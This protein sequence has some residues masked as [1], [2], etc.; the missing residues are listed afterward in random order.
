MELQALHC[1][2]MASSTSPIPATSSSAGPSTSSLHSLSSIQQLLQ[3]THNLTS[4]YHHSLSQLTTRLHTL[5]D[6]TTRLLNEQHRLRLGLEWLREKGQLLP[7]SPLPTPAATAAPTAATDLTTTLF[8]LFTQPTASFTSRPF[9]Y[10]TEVCYRR[11]LWYVRRHPKAIVPAALAEANPTV[12]LEQRRWLGGLCRGLVCDVMGDGRGVAEGD[13]SPA[14]AVALIEATLVRMQTVMRKRTERRRAEEDEARLQKDRDDAQQRQVVTQPSQPHSNAAE[15]MEDDESDVTTSTSSTSPLP[16][17]TITTT[18]ST[19]TSLLS[20]TNSDIPIL[21]ASSSFT[22]SVLDHSSLPLKL[23]HEFNLRYG[24]RYLQSTLVSSIQLVLEEQHVDLN[25]DLMGPSPRSAGPPTAGSSAVAGGG[26]GEKL[27]GICGHLMDAIVSSA[28]AMPPGMRRLTRLLFRLGSSATS[29]TA[30]FST[31]TTGLMSSPSSPYRLVSDYLFLNYLIN[32]LM[33]P[34]SY[35]LLPLS[36]P[37]LSP[38]HRRNLQVVAT[39]LIKVMSGSRFVFEGGRLQQLN[40]AVEEWRE[41]VIRF[42]DGL[43]DDDEAGS[44]AVELKEEG[45][46]VGEESGEGEWEEEGVGEDREVVDRVI[47]TLPNDLFCLH[48]VLLG[49][50]RDEVERGRAQRQLEREQ[51]KASSALHSPS[52]SSR[53][54]PLS[55]LV[56]LLVQMDDPP[57]YLSLADNLYILL[58]S[59]F[60]TLAVP[61][62]PPFPSSSRTERLCADMLSYVLSLLPRL[63][64]PSASSTSA[65]VLTVLAAEAQRAES[66][67][68][69]ATAITVAECI[70]LLSSSLPLTNLADFLTSLCAHLQSYHSLLTSSSLP[71]R[72]LLCTGEVERR[73]E[74]LKRQE[75]EVRDGLRGLGVRRVME[76]VRVR[77]KR[78]RKF[79]AQRS[80]KEKDKLV[81]QDKDRP[82]NGNQALDTTQQTRDRR[83]SAP[84]SSPLYVPPPPAY[85]STLLTGGGCSGPWPADIQSDRFLC[86]GCMRLLDKRRV[87]LRSFYNKYVIGEPIGTATGVDVAAA[88]LGG[89]SATLSLAV[90]LPLAPAVSSPAVLSNANSSS[91]S[92][93]LSASAPSAG[94]TIGTEPGLGHTLLNLS[95][96]PPLNLLDQAVMCDL[97]DL[98]C[99][100]VWDEVWVDCERGEKQWW[101]ECEALRQ[102][103]LAD[104]DEAINDEATGSDRLDD[105]EMMR[106]AFEVWYALMALGEREVGGD[107]GVTVAD[108]RRLLQDKQQQPSTAGSATEQPLQRKLQQLSAPWLSSHTVVAFERELYGMLH[109]KSCRDKL[110]C[111][112][113]MRSIVFAS[114]ANGSMIA[115]RRQQR[116]D[117]SESDVEAGSVDD[118]M[119]LLSFLLVWLNPL[120]VLPHLSF[121]RLLHVPAAQHKAMVDVL[122]AVKYVYFMQQ[123]LASAKAG[124]AGAVEF[125]LNAD[126]LRQRVASRGGRPASS[127]DGMSGRDSSVSSGVEVDGVPMAR[128]S[129]QPSGLTSSGGGRPFARSLSSLDEH[130]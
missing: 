81:I 25:I 8:A 91:A 48:W 41:R 99:S 32:A 3:T 19:L 116:G 88:A 121:L 85:L 5:D 94:V 28:A 114:L 89:N 97:N 54:V 53:S 109:S 6:R 110:D 84:T 69:A 86:A 67:G 122:T 62:L 96:G 4:S 83:V 45:E 68:N 82:V 64:P 78:L 34:S 40:E 12:L 37:P 38:L 51:R 113:R 77:V 18:P 124:A 47:A 33:H 46:E 26:A 106:S 43:V 31:S 74:E 36:S 23:L 57:P 72:L 59:G 123:S 107:S 35:S 2:S 111:I 71:S 125:A 100:A 56:A 87:L 21:T 75:A 20:S 15:H 95:L 115:L 120:S 7:S 126:R 108:V 55:P 11:L 130:E 24:Q 80:D 104:V 129:S 39:V 127:V 50:K 70:A 105:D 112:G 101:V 119:S 98:I 30:S 102:Q 65:S 76:M 117:S 17:L 58:S 9:S 90:P 10:H 52:S 63:M 16:A 61:S 44:T 29:S 73:Q 1:H 66:T 14:S 49:W 92:A 42:I 128:S 93:S 60:P 118:Y 22:F 79:L 103:L 13:G 27:F